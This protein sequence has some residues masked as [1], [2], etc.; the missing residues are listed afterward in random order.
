M[1]E[2]R[3]LKKRPFFDYRSAQLPHLLLGKFHSRVE[4]NSVMTAERNTL[5]WIKSTARTLYVIALYPFLFL[6]IVISIA[7]DI[8]YRP[9]LHKLVDARNTG[10]IQAYIEQ[11][12]DLDV[13]DRAMQRTALHQSALLGLTQISQLLIEAGASTQ[14][15]DKEGATPLY[16]AALGGHTSI[17]ELL[18]FV[19]QNIAQGGDPNSTF[20]GIGSALYIASKHGYLEIVRLLLKAGANPNRYARGQSPL[21][22]AMQKG[23]TEI[24]ELLVSSGAKIT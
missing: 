1:V 21:K 13:C 16:I 6:W 18:A 8:Y 5:W 22:V 23:H 3:S 24:V 15:K 7:L 11:G 17:V 4:E 2:M 10:A 20:G 9:E 12:K 14:I 19:E